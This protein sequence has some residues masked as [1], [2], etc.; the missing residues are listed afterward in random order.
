MSCCGRLDAFGTCTTCSCCI[1]HRVLLL[2]RE[3]AGAGTSGTGI[4][5]M[6]GIASNGI[7]LYGDAGR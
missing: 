7:A 5:G 3:Q 2:R 4:G 6:I 1:R